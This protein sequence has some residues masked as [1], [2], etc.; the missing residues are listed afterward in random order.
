[1]SRPLTKKAIQSL[2]G[3]YSYNRGEAD[4]RAGKVRITDIDAE[5]STYIATVGGSSSPFRVKIDMDND[6]DIHADCECLSLN[7]SDKLC[8]L[9]RIYGYRSR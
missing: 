4:Y 5:R 2:C 6:G 8:R 1:M 9:F 3:S 7:L